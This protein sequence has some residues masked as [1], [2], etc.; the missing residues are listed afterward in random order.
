MA[1]LLNGPS[2]LEDQKESIQKM[3][4]MVERFETTLNEYFLEDNIHRLQEEL[5]L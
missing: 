3:L 5:N 4:D 2:Y 1:V